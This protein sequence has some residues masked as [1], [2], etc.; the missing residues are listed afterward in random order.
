[1]SQLAYPMLILDAPAQ[2][3]GDCLVDGSASC[4]QV[5]DL[6]LPVVLKSGDFAAEK[7]SQQGSPRG[8]LG[9]QDPPPGSQQCKP[10]IQCSL[11]QP[12]WVR[13]QLLPSALGISSATT[14]LPRTEERSL[15]GNA[16]RGLEAGRSPTWLAQVVCRGPPL[17]DR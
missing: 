14:P 1:M 6:I 10:C 11:P 17:M 9:C 3:R 13:I 4:V 5:P 2:L 12:C 16:P 8:E 7:L 15:R